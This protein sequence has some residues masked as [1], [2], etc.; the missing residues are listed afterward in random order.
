MTRRAWAITKADEDQEHRKHDELHESLTCESVSQATPSEEK[1]NSGSRKM[2][3]K[4]ILRSY[5][6]RDK[7]TIFLL[8]QR[9]KIRFSLLTNYT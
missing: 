2:K 7:S 9:R 1:E 4:T 3:F 6:L 5:V 8:L